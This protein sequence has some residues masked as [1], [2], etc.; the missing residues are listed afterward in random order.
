MRICCTKVDIVDVGDMFSFVD[1][2]RLEPNDMC[3]LVYKIVSID[4][5]Q[6]SIR[7]K[8]NLCFYDDKEMRIS[9]LFN[10]LPTGNITLS[11]KKS[12]SGRPI[13]KIT[14]HED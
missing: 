13:Y 7:C 8:Y 3:E 1:L 10:N 12:F 2:S 11:V 5:M 14:L 6:D 4:L 9:E